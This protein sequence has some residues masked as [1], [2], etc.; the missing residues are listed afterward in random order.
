MWN[1][2]IEFGLPASAI[3]E[4]AIISRGN[5]EIIDENGLLN[6][7]KFKKPVREIIKQSLQ[8]SFQKGYTVITDSI[9]L[10]ACLTNDISYGVKCCQE[11]GIKPT[12]LFE[13]LL[14][15]YPKQSIQKK[16]H[17]VL[18]YD[19]CSRIV[20]PIYIQIQKSMRHESIVSEKIFFQTS[21]QRSCLTGL[22]V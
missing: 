19:I 8:I 6:L 13:I 12:M 1:Q 21:W 22:T 16:S 4:K 2:M 11:A 9:L 18:D 5:I 7:S 10:G 14:G 3:M 20:I 15:L 17:P